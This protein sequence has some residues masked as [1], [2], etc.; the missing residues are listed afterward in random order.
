MNA[1]LRTALV[2]SAVAVALIVPLGPSLATSRTETW[3]DPNFV[4]CEGM[5][6][7]ATG[8]V[9]AHVEYTQTGQSIRVTSFS[10]ESAYGFPHEPSATIRYTDPAGT[11]PQLRLQEPW[12]PQVGPA[13]D[14]AR[15]LFLPR[16]GSGRGPAAQSPFTMR[17][18]TPVRIS[19]NVRFPQAGG[20]CFASFSADLV[21]P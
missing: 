18:G 20:S 15:H 7:L 5:G 1:W 16:A 4:P 6:A 17:A 12:F 3:T 8:R 10:L 2:C 14:N 21:L 11:L 19:L 13:G 9:R